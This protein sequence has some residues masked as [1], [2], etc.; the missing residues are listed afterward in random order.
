MVVGGEIIYSVINTVEVPEGGKQN[1]PHIS[2]FLMGQPLS[3]SVDQTLFLADS[4]NLS[5]YDPVRMCN[6][7]VA[8]VLRIVVTS[9][10]TYA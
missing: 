7:G 4:K 8:G 5:R 10:D 9:W 2:C 1:S 6:N 3:F